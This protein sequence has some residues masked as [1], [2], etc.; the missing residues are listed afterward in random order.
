MSSGAA[1]TLSLSCHWGQDTHLGGSRCG[2]V[3]KAAAL[4]SR[5]RGCHRACG[6]APGGGRHGSGEEW[7]GAGPALGDQGVRG[8][9]WCAAPSCTTFGGRMWPNLVQG[10]AP[11]HLAPHFGARFGARFGVGFGVVQGLCLGNNT[12]SG[13]C[14]TA[15]DPS[16]NLTKNLEKFGQK[17]PRGFNCRICKRIAFFGAGKGGPLCGGLLCNCRQL[18]FR[19]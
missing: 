11:H 19:V 12:G 14:R 16:T 17:N 1:C 4:V 3:L 15:P 7:R 2:A 10:G 8:A 5:A 13:L 9:R 18:L 6:G